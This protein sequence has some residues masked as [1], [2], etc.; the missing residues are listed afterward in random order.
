MK[1]TPLEVA[2]ATWGEPL[3]DWIEALALACV[4]S[5]QSKVA[6]KLD[7]TGGMI[8]QLLNNKYPASTANIEERVRGVYLDGQVICPSLGPLAVNLCQD[9][10]IKAK[11]F[12]VGNPMRIRMF[13]ACSRCPRFLETSNE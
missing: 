9:W 12:Q 10:R 5:S 7:R 2:R 1:P 4:A 13:R 11:D 8:S 3:P 6:A